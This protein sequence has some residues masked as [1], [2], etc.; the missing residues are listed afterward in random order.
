MQQINAK[1]K[2]ISLSTEHPH[3]RGFIQ[4]TYGN[5]TIYT[6]KGTEFAIC[7]EGVKIEGQEFMSAVEAARKLKL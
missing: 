2:L 3:K 6:Y 1:H 7:R 4:K 5:H